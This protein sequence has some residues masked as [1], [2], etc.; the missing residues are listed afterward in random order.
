M[1]HVLLTS[2]NELTA[3]KDS[4]RERAGLEL[5]MTYLSRSLVFAF[6]SG[7]EQMGGYAIN[8]TGE[9]CLSFLPSDQRVCLPSSRLVEV[10][11]LWAKRD[12]PLTHKLWMYW[13]MF[14]DVMF[15]KPDVVLSGTTVQ[16]LSGPQGLV[17]NQ[18]IYEGRWQGTNKVGWIYWG[19]TK[20]MFKRFAA[21]L[22]WIVLRRARVSFG[23]LGGYAAF[24]R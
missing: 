11:C 15:L 14:W 20:G 21:A 1:K 24:Q 4:Y 23:K 7:G 19:K 10:T 9:R 18:T 12:L 17:L 13:N 5:H 3:F 22:G 6:V 2:E 8:K 16:Q